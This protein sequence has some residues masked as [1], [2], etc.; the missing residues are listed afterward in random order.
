M[1]LTWI[2]QPDQ[3][4][5]G[6]YLSSAGAKSTA[7]PGEV[8]SSPSTEDQS[9]C[10]RNDVVSVGHVE[11]DRS[12]AHVALLD[13][14]EDVVVGRDVL[15]S[16][17][18]SLRV[19]RTCCRAPGWAANRRRPRSS[20]LVQVVDERIAVHVGISGL[21]DLLRISH[22]RAPSLGVVGDSVPLF[23]TGNWRTCR[24]P[25]PGPARWRRWGRERSERPPPVIR[26]SRGAP[27]HRLGDSGDR[28]RPT[29]L[30]TLSVGAATP[31]HLLADAGRRRCEGELEMRCA[32]WS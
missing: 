9:R 27:G 5:R 7:R 12:L 26:C 20:R 17:P 14:V 4:D 29:I 22:D 11:H 2:V 3:D 32:W 31:R 30:V 1:H 18:S 13:H 8:A 23:L 19:G 24:L 16:G 21:S 15:V 6:D 28:P 25:D 10:C